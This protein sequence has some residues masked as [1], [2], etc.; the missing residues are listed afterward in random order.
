[1]MHFASRDVG[2]LGAATGTS[3]TAGATGGFEGPVSQLAN[4][5][6]TT[7]MRSDRMKRS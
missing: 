3:E 2:G 6:T 5:K 1:M 7:S 4:G